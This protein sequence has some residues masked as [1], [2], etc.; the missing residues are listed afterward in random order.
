MLISK[1]KNS[2]KKKDKEL[3]TKRRKITYPVK[4]FSL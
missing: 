2:E 4:L 3:K 1:K